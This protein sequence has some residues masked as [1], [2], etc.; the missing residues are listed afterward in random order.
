MTL[1]PGS[2]PVEPGRYWDFE[3]AGAEDGRTDEEYP[4]SSTACSARRSSASS[5]RTSRSAPSSAAGWTRARITAAGGPDAALPEHVHGRLRHDLQHG[6]RARQRRAPKAEAMS[7]LFRT[8]HYEAVLK[9]GDME[10]CLP[11]LVWHLEDLRVGQSYPNYYV[12]RL[13]SKFVK[14]VL[15]RVGR[16]RALRRLSLA[17]LPGRRQRRL[18]PL[19]REV[20][21]LLAPA[22]PERRCCRG[23]FAPR[24][25]TRSGSADDRHLPRRPSPTRE[26]PETPRSTSTTRST[27]R[28]RPSCTGCSWSRTSSAWPTS[29]ENRVPFLD[30]DLV[31][32][33]QRRPGAAASSATSTQV[34]ELDENEPGP[35][36]PALLR[37]DPR[38][39]AA[40]PRR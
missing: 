37:E 22:D 2:A 18:R 36:D 7:Y 40:A 9:A 8:E 17:L 20:L 30:N 25:G 28:R 33:A 10:R 26:A 19:R 1:S 16:R 34:V 39:Q 5:S 23:F 13:A 14:V 27:W 4:R 35:E 38:R 24:S 29:L 3:F 6:P 15:D 31:D 11:S 12:A 21:P 32:F